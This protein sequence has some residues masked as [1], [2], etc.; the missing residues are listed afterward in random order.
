MPTLA[1]RQAASSNVS[2]G[3]PSTTYSQPTGTPWANGSPSNG[4]T[5]LYL[6]TFLITILV[7]G[8][9]SSGLLIR[10]Y[11]LRR[12]FHRRV[13]AAIRSG[14]PLPPDAAA[15]LG[16]TP[17]RRGKKEKK[18]GLMPTMWESEMWRRGEKDGD[19]EEDD[20]AHE[21][22]DV[23]EETTPLSVVHFPAPSP[24]PT[25]QPPMTLD[26]IPRQSARTRIRHAFSSQPPMPIRPQLQTQLT[27]QTIP[28]A[29]AMFEI[30]PVGTEVMLG[31]MIAMPVQG[32]DEERW[33]LL[34]EGEERD[35]PE[36]CLGVMN[37]KIGE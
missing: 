30:P 13:E 27:N 14:Q 21:K 15:A 4:S 31:V 33:N 7:L 22:A 35:L 18:H 10:A 11:V 8:V 37:A 1:Q 26:M 5:T 34:E 29:K 2:S 3:T 6:F 36:V 20:L 16:L 23:W 12:R 19:V 17:R 28:K 24:P 32:A 25:P 9:I